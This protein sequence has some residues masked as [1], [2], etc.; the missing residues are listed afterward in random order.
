MKHFKK[1]LSSKVGRV[2]QVLS[3]TFLAATFFS[4][5]PAYEIW[6]FTPDNYLGENRIM[7]ICGGAPVP[8]ESNWSGFSERDL[9]VLENNDPHFLY[10]FLVVDGKPIRGPILSSTRFENIANCT[11]KKEFVLIGK[12]TG[13][14]KRWEDTLPIDD[15]FQTID[16]M[17]MRQYEMRTRGAN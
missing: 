6:E 11:D 13:V 2:S 8:L 16:A 12:D 1:Y 7:L 5:V 3:I 9:I 4:I 14:K 15:L 10:L 17:P